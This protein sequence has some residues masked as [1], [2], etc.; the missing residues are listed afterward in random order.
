[1]LKRWVQGGALL[2]AILCSQVPF[3]QGP[4]PPAS[5]PPIGQAPAG[6]RPP[7]P[8]PHRPRIGLALSGGG[9]RGVAH[10]GVL[11]ALEE[12][13]IPVDFIAGTSAGAIMGGLY[14]TGMTPD[15]LDR[16]FT[17]IDWNTV[18][19]D[20]APYRDLP[21]RRKDELQTYPPA[22][23]MGISRHGIEMPKG[24]VSGQKQ[25]FILETSTLRGA[26]VEDFDRLPIPFRAVATDLVA[27]DSVILSR[28][29]LSQAM[30]ASMSVPGAFAPVVMGGRM[31]VD[32]GLVDNLPVDVVRSMGADIVI[33]VNIG[34]PLADETQ[35]RSVLQIL[36]QAMS[37]GIER[38]VRESLK[39]A[40]IVIQPDLEGFSAARFGDAAPIIARGH[41]AALAAVDALRPYA[42]TPEAFQARLAEVRNA[43]P[44]YREDRPLDFVRVEGT[45]RADPGY[46]LKRIKTKPG[47]PLDPKVLDQDLDL[48]RGT[49]DF[50]SV[51]YRTVLEDDRM[52]IVIEAEEKSWGPTYLLA[53]INVEDDFEGDGYTDLRLRINHRPANRYGAE[54]RTDLELGRRRRLYTE[55]YQP[56]GNSGRWF[57]A[58]Y[59]DWD[60]TVADVYEGSRK[61]A[62]YAVHSVAAGLDAGVELGLWGEARVGLR[63][64]H[65]R[66]VVTAG[67]NVYQNVD[68]KVAALT[69]GFIQDRLDSPYIPTRGTYAYL[70][71]AF[72]RRS[73]GSETSYDKLELFWAGYGGWGRNT[74][75]LNLQ[76]GSSLGTSPPPYDWFE[77]GGFMD[78]SGYA[79]GQLVGPYA[80]LARMGY[81]REIAR[82]PSRLGRGLYAGLWFE[83][84]DVWFSASD[85]G[86]GPLR[87]SATLALGADTILGPMFL[88]YSKAQRNQGVFTL[89]IGRRF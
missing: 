87:T 14:A 71:G 32:G 11:R 68:F 27:G 1:M 48:I 47:R 53:A 18:F 76:G 44:P 2:V 49:G 17:S 88:A 55:F 24:F 37:I 20:A 23:E 85:F 25:A 7:S 50:Q 43:L 29:R 28:G 5:E 83:A 45:S 31:L 22:L 64:G 65:T 19:V 67:S 15:D 13:H 73:M 10:A 40:D 77:L 16:L 59:L 33:A 34:T 86:S 21:F 46:V 84:G 74:F 62:E 75:F 4:P 81:Y 51:T 9:A 57:V 70:Q 63:R 66:A 56:V 80:G 38:N 35:L 3:A 78:F 36:L 61:R 30:Q 39:K 79:N 6:E 82:L 58:P 12:L 41:E 42:M 60:N 69:A 89:S 8:V 26:G 52:G 72:S 54:W